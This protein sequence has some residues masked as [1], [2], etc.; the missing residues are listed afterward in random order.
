MPTFATLIYSPL[1]LIFDNYDSFTYNLCD[2]FKQLGQ[3]LLVIRNDEKSPEEIEALNFSGIVISPGPGVPQ[4]SGI[5][6]DLI[7][8]WHNKV[9]IL[10]ICLGHQALG[11]Y[12][13]WQL[14]K[15]PYPM[16][17]KV[18]TI[19]TLN[20][21]MWHNLPKEINVCRYHSLVLSEE[22][23]IRE[24]TNQGRSGDTNQG[25]TKSQLLITARSK[26]DNAIM[27]IAHK[28]LPIWGIQFHPEAILTQYGKEILNNWLNAFILHK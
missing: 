15:A 19:E 18:S 3:E 9:P 11:T 25:E 8:R 27:A 17:G 10:G 12:F 6:M 16:H 2:Y 23:L 4:N 26:D 20:H 22:E 24:D 7:N 14:I 13:G 1:L 5:L 28:N 21:P